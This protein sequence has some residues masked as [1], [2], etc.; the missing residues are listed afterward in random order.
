MR[1]DVEAGPMNQHDTTD[2]ERTREQRMHDYYSLLHAVKYNTGTPDGP[3]PQPAGVRKP[4]IVQNRTQAGYDAAHIRR[5]ID[6]ARDN[7]HLFAYRDREGDV[8]LCTGDREG[9]QALIAQENRR[10]DTRTELIEAAR[11]VLA[12]E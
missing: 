3:S 1:N 9:I 4:I 8:R 2:D 6:R 10:E 11:E 7:G 12:D 5:L